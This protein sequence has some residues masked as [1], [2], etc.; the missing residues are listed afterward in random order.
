M[1][2]DRKNKNKK[3]DREKEIGMF[4]MSCSWFND[5]GKASFVKFETEYPAEYGWSLGNLRIGLCIA[6]VYQNLAIT[7]GQWE[8]LSRQIE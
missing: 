3:K 2:D 6:L 1:G 8:G 7:P 4:F 5:I